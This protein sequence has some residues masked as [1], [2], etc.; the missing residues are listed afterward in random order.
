MKQN[1]N[2]KEMLATCLTICLLTGCAP[3]IYYPNMVCD[4]SI[5]DNKM[6]IIDAET[7]V[8][9]VVML[10]D[11]K[12][13]QKNLKYTVKG[14]SINVSADK[15]DTDLV[16]PKAKIKFNED[17]IYARIQQEWFNQAKKPMKCL[18]CGR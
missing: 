12:E 6:L 8:S 11:D 2:L 17:T 15:Y 16:L 18:D 5:K 1:K 4:M 7:K 3:T 13:T 10:P 9:R 14:D